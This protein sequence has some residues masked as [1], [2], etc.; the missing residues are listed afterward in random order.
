M[1]EELTAF[2]PAEYLNSD[3][4]RTYFLDDAFET[5]DPG[6][7]AHAIGIVA[8]AAG[9]SRLASETGLAR[10]ALYRSFS[11]EGNPSLKS[12]L[13]VLAALGYRLTVAPAQQET[14]PNL[15]GSEAAE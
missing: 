8:R 3:E 1:A 5:G 14:A 12:L 10:E 6:Y 7:I 4:A 11:E 15:A 9:M 13:A 2:D